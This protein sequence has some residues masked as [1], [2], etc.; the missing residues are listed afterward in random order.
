MGIGEV[1]AGIGDALDVGV[2]V[3][4]G[5]VVCGDGV[6]GAGL[7][8]DELESPSA[9]LVGRS[10]V[11]LSDLDVPGLSFHEGDDAR[12]AVA[13]HCV[14]LP[15]SDAGAVVGRGG[16][17]LDRPLSGQSSSRVVGAVSLTSQFGGAAQVL[18]DG[19]TASFVSPDVTINGLVADLEDSVATEPSSDLL[20]A[21]VVLE[22]FLDEIPVSGGEAEVPPRVRP[23][24]AR[25]AVRLQR[26]VE[27][28]RS[29]AVCVGPLD[30]SNLDAVQGSVRSQ[31]RLPL[32]VS[33]PK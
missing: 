4:F 9:E 23:P 8:V 29:P 12:P 11:E 31:P 6:Y 7:A 28:I 20:G 30:R 13:E 26:P 21:P 22:Q 16:S 5:S 2:A 32:F 19:A 10:R 18:V 17:V 15:V 3:E 14:G 25:V 33:V 24:G 1:E 27:S